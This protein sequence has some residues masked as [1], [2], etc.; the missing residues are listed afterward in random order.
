MSE[1]RLDLIGAS[2]APAILGLDDYR[3]P[4]DVWARIV[5]ELREPMSEPAHWGTVIEPLVL[6][7]FAELHGVTV[8]KPPSIVAP[9]GRE[10]QRVS[11]DGLVREWPG[12]AVEVKCVSR[13]RAASLGHEGTDEVLETHLVQVQAQMEALDLDRVHVLYLV[14]GNSYREY[15]VRRSEQLGAIVREECERFWRDFVIPR[16]PPPAFGRVDTIRK[17][18]PRALSPSR[19]AS[20]E[21]IELARAYLAAKDAVAAAERVEDAARAALCEAIGPSAGLTGEGIEARW[22]EVARA[23]KPDWERVAGELARQAGMGPEAL[24][25]LA[26]RHLEGGSSHRRLTVRQKKEKNV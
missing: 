14:G 17:L 10:W 13:E 12:E 16:R 24:R 25:Q 23:A 7:R 5:H 15:L 3:G 11:L 20:A 6:Q 21:E 2:D 1:L 18:F 22:S 19:A 8:E 4:G 26:A 9:K